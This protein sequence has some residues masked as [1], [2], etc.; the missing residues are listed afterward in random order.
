MLKQGRIT[1][2]VP[3]GGVS[4]EWHWAMMGHWRCKS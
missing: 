2:V 3:L 1:K 4:H